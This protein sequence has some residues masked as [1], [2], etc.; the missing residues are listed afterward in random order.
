MAN[1]GTPFGRDAERRS[2]SPTESEQGFPCDAAERALFNQL[3][4]RLEA[5]VGHVIDHAGI[6]QTDARFTQLREAIQSLIAAAT[7]S[8]DTSQFLL[9]AQA[10]AR[11]PIFPEVLTNDGLMNVSS[12]GIGSVRVPGGV[13]FL[14]RGI[15]PINTTQTDFPTDASKVYHLRWDP[16]NGFRLRDLASPT[17]NPTTLAESNT[18]FDSTYDDM[19][20]AR[21]ITNSS[22]I[23]TITN[24]VNKA[25]IVTTVV[26]NSALATG[27][28]S[29]V[30]TL[31]FARVGIPCLAS[32]V[33]PGGNRD[34]DV[35]VRVDGNTRYALTIYSWGWQA[36]AP[37]GVQS[38]FGYVYNVM[39]I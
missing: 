3:F 13:A 20:V 6:A 8:G 19:L 32:I 14:H 21:V 31:N 34:S 30:H 26:A 18:F 24:L 11:L 25:R 36:D 28:R 17:Y 16:T 12:P 7:G 39:C 15:F 33:P 10:R 9:T 5:E 4:Y 1:F 35:F 29:L 22:N 37:G 38:S 23:A 2:P 27:G